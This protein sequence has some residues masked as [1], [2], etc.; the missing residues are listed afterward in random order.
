MASTS[1]LAAVEQRDHR[2][3]HVLAIGHDLGQ[4]GTGKHAALGPRMARADG[5]VIGVE[6][7]LVGGIEGAV[8]ARMR[9]QHEGLEEPGGVRQVPLGRAGVGHRLD[10]LV[11]GR[12]WFSELLGE[13]ADVHEPL[14]AMA[15]V[16]PHAT[17]YHDWTRH[18]RPVG[19]RRRR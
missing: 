18:L 2:V 8:A 19:K 3:R 7:I 17:R 14:A 5:F 4:A 9:A 16:R 12:Q 15:A 1:W 13:G 10:R 11:L 6:E